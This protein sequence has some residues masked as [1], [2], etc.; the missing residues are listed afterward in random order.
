MP[1]ENLEKI[2]LKDLNL[3]Q[4][5]FNI[6]QNQHRPNT[7]LAATQHSVN[8]QPEPESA[9]QKILGGAKNLL[10]S[11]ATAPFALAELPGNIY[12]AVTGHTP[13]QMSPS[14]RLYKELG[15]TEPENVFSRALNYTAGNWPLLL[16][17]GPV[18]GGKVATDLASSLGMSAA[19]EAGFGALG[20]LAGG[21]LG[22]KGFNHASHALK[23]AAQ[24]APKNPTKYNEFISSWYDK[25]EKL[26]EAIPENGKRL[27]EGLNNIFDKV[28][29][30]YVNPN[31]F[32]EAARNRVISNLKTA[33]SNLTKEGLT[34]K[35]I[36][37]E[38]KNLN[39]AYGWKDSTEG[40][41]YAEIR[42]L[43]TDELEDI[44]KRHPEFGNA[45]KTADELYQIRNAQTRL[46]EWAAKKSEDGTLNSLLSNKLALGALGLLTGGSVG[47]LKGLGLGLAHEGAKLGAKGLDYGIREAR[48]L[49][50]VLSTEGGKKL[51]MDIS[52]EAAKGNSIKLASSLKKLNQLANEYQKE[53]RSS[54]R[55]SIPLK[56]LDLS[57]YNFNI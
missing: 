44:G 36:F 22:A 25:A 43:F 1:L 32:D 14:Q 27:N 55:E 23:S 12:N 47:S 56:D 8:K 57:Q 33:E 39:K 20:Q 21:V 45:Y 53:D 46:G 49:N 19:E 26:G 5:D 7:D 6:P 9:T 29:K 38:K 4:Y 50:K 54:G 13:N 18:T 30:E 3:D 16:L 35:D 11:A 31:K 42:K 17:G 10:A 51:I 15:G 41:Y 24:K 34:A 40:K 48:F 52:I 28:K 2:P 37:N